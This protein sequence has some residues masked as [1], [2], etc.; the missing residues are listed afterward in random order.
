MLYHGFAIIVSCKHLKM[1]SMMFINFSH[2]KYNVFGIENFDRFSHA[3]V[4]SDNAI[5]RRSNLY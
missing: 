1:F 3:L 5:F 2:V 4:I